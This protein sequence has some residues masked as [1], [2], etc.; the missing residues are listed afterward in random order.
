M[1]FI[2]SKMRNSLGESEHTSIAAPLAA[3]TMAIL[4]LLTSCDNN[5]DIARLDFNEKGKDYKIEVNDGV[6][7][8]HFAMNED[9]WKYIDY[10]ISSS[11][12][13]KT[14]KIT[15]YINGKTKYEGLTN[16]KIDK[17]LVYN[18]EQEFQ[19]RFLP[20]ASSV[21]NQWFNELIWAMFPEWIEGLEWWNDW[22]KG[23]IERFD[24]LK[25]R[26][27]KL[28]LYNEN[29]EADTI[30]SKQW[31]SIKTTIWDKEIELISS[32]MSVEWKDGKKDDVY[33]LLVNNEK[34]G[35][36]C[37]SKDFEDCYATIKKDLLENN[38]SALGYEDEAKL[39]G[40]RLAA[41]NN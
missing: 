20:E 29:K 23:K 8:L 16:T 36:V 11:K 15:V 10:S 39:T 26:A 30:V 33:N 38:D 34:I 21:I 27:N 1:L 13:A 7:S 28:F 22:V 37:L 18:N 12:D 5:K 19:E 14:W 32:E 4:S 2:I 6:A 35:Y 24:N 17:N 3:S 31:N 40:I 25:R 41:K 9:K